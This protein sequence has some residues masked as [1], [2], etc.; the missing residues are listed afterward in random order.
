MN[1]KKPCEEQGR[2]RNRSCI[3]YGKPCK[4]ETKK[5]LG[6]K[7]IHGIDW[8]QCQ[9]LNNMN[10]CPVVNGSWGEWSNFGSCTATCGYGIKFE[11]ILFFNF[12]NILFLI[13]ILFW[14]KGYA[15]VNAIILSQVAM[16]IT[17]QEKVKTIELAF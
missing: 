17:V 2:H 1:C 11:E 7:E 12:E 5:I 10:K 8:E 4:P 14:V 13:L 9:D 3:G 16:V 6:M 15:S